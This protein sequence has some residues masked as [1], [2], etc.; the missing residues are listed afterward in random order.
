MKRGASAQVPN[1]FARYQ[2]ALPISKD[3]KNDL[4]SLCNSGVMP[5]VHAPF[6]IALPCSTQIHDSAVEPLED[7]DD[8]LE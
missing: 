3:K 8:E 5:A 2:K 7:S 1:L 6:L 4:L